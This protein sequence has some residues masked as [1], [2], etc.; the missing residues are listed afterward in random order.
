MRVF[1]SAWFGRFVRK[2]KIAADVLWD[3]VERAERGL[4]DADLGGG[5]IKQR[6]ARPGAGKSKGYRTILIFRK[7]DKAVFVYGFPKSELG[8]IAGDELEQFKNAARSILA[9]SEDQ[10]RQLVECGQFE[11]VINH[12]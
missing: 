1:K 7:G 11:E 4:I 5:V 3:A 8:N 2:Q 6:I 12:G 10:I 9:L